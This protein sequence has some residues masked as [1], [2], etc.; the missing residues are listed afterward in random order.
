M[1]ET[2]YI[3]LRFCN[4]VPEFTGTDL[5]THGPFQVGDTAKIPKDSAEVLIARGSAEKA[6]ETGDGSF[7][8]ESATGIA[9]AVEVVEWV[10]DTEPHEPK[11]IKLHHNGTE[12]GTF[13]K[14]EM[15]S[16]C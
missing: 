13:V 1:S 11:K 3:E 6:G 7:D 9:P 4:R 16:D 2:E 8:F 14:E 10:E 15:S 12:F 5:E